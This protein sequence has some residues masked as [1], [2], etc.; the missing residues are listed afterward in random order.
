MAGK[1]E[2]A[3][4]ETVFIPIYEVCDGIVSLWIKVMFFKPLPKDKD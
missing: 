2:C 4:T 1:K 3:R